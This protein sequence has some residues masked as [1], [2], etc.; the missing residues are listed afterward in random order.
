[1][2]CGEDTTDSSNASNAP[3]VNDFTVQ[4]TLPKALSDSE[5]PELRAEARLGE[6]EPTELTVNED[7]TI[8]G[9]LNNKLP[10]THEL[11]ITYFVIIE[12]IKLT[13]ATVSKEII[14]DAGE[15]T[16]VSIVDTDFNKNYDEDGDGYTN[17]AELKNGTSPR[18]PNAPNNKPALFYA[19]S[20]ASSNSYSLTH[21]VGASL[22]G[23]SISTN[24]TAT[25]SASNFR[26]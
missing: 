9:S 14:V 7:K 22:S 16:H 19:S 5:I 26:K 11:H 23:T 3:K 20:N 21:N 8:T 12:T 4:L 24:Y 18:V 10:G 1:M 13:L 15:T 25:V 17:L 2:G 6:E